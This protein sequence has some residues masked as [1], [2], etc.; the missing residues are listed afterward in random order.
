MQKQ[1]LMGKLKHN[2]NRY[3]EGNNLYTHIRYR[4]MF[5]NYTIDIKQIVSL[6]HDLNSVFNTLLKTNF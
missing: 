5:E 4:V 1:I 3:N 6:V 2:V